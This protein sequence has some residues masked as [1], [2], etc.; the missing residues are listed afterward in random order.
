[1]TLYDELMTLRTQVRKCRE[2][3]QQVSQVKRTVRHLMTGTPFPKTLLER[4]AIQHREKFLSPR[5]L[6]ST[7]VIVPV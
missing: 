2:V 7:L 1:M 6:I 3:S 4:I 5:M